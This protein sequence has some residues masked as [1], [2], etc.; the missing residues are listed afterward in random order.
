MFQRLKDL[1]RKELHW[2]V[3]PPI[4]SCF[5][6]ITLAIGENVEKY[7]VYAMP[8]LQSADELYVH[9][10]GADEENVEWTNLLINDILEAYS[11]IFQGFKN[12]P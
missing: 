12:S 8:M 2:S 5:G 1:S 3:R 7:L 6:D 11:G 4:F 9:T 10:F